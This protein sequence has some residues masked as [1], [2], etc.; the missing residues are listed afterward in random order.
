[1]NVA[2]HRIDDG[3]VIA[4]IG[5]PIEPVRFHARE[6]DPSCDPRRDL[7]AFVNARWRAAHALPPDR[8]SWDCFA[9]LRERSLQIQ[10]HIAIESAAATERSEAARVVGDLW[11]SGLADDD[12]TGALRVELARIAALATPASIAAYL[13]ERHARGWPLLFAF[14]V[15]PA[16]DA[17]REPIACIGQGGLG[18]PDCTAYFDTSMTPVR[19]AYAEHVA[20]LLAWSGEADPGRCATQV[21][22]FETRLA[23]VSLSRRELARDIAL[24]QRRIALAD[25]DANA[26][27]RTTGFSWRDFFA[28][29]D[30]APPA[31]FS[32]A[33]PAF[34]AR[35]Q[36]MLA[37]TAPAA[38]R[39]YLAFHT[40][41]S[42][43]G[44]LGGTI[45]A[46]WH[47][48]HGQQQR[49][50]DRPRPPWKRVIEA[51][52]A[53]AGEALG[54]LYVARTFP[55][56]ARSAVEGIAE[57]LRHAF[58]A[59]I[60]ALDWM[61]A[62]TKSAARRKLAAMRCKIGHAARWP[63]W[64]AVRTSPLGWLDNLL[65]VRAFEQRRRVTRLTE[66]VDPDAWTMTPQ[67]INAGYDPQRNEIVFP[68]AILQP[69]FFDP[70]ADPA[71]NYGGIGAVIAHE[72]THAFDD[73]GSRFGADGRFDNAWDEDDLAR[74]GARAQRLVDAF[75]AMP[76]IGG[77]HVDGRLTLGENIADFGGLAIA[78]D[79]FRALLAENS[80]ADPMID[81]YDQRQRFF[82]AWAT[83]WRQILAAPEG[84]RRLRID[85]HSPAAL[86]ANAPAADLHA[87]AE[88]FDTGA[89]DSRD[90]RIE[91]P[92][93]LW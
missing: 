57:R 31:Y 65:A 35:W 78:C 82:F 92:L 29:H 54:E 80:A 21:L 8:S 52:D 67:T 68:A 12:D 34:H 17:P 84:R 87:F 36:A 27:D 19:A 93:G 32:L 33:V 23:A 44:V 86:R 69:P 25:A 14:D 30:I 7:D 53:G 5:T 24:C 42:L 77:S 63:D 43:G 13:C 9:M 10:A 26:D 66:P 74:F 48:F 51:I 58:D 41:D 70:T 6:L 64:S 55:A 50:A 40:I 46:A 28:A 20:A 22:A 83:I 15:S 81:G 73:Q 60:A 85:P 71:L 90:R 47:R 56:S 37:D 38:W 49:G 76:G 75:D 89:G 45:G 59:R 16:F 11:R 62:T 88:A 2:A 79:A 61:S 1:M 18:L 39:A 91:V 72:M 4:A 3:D